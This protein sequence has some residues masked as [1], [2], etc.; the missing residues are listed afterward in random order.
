MS[1][2]VRIRLELELT[3]VGDTLAPLVNLF[4][5]NHPVMPRSRAIRWELV[6]LNDGVLDLAVANITN[7]TMELKAYNSP[8]S[9]PIISKFITGASINAA[10]TDAQRQGKSDQ[11][12]V[13]N[14][15]Q[16]DTG[17]D[18]AGADPDNTKAFSLVI[19]ATR[20]GNLV[21]LGAGAIRV[22]NDGGQYSGNTPTAGDPTFYTKDQVD[23]LLGSYM[24]LLNDPGVRLILRNKENTWEVQRY[25]DENGVEVVARKKL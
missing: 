15:D 19:T 18:M 8:T 25:I 4:T 22:L 20:N 16:G 24:K 23:G 1:D 14:F 7:V 13:I 9:P 21:T 12:A 10:L 17:V 2:R 3:K 11:H 6:F 5:G